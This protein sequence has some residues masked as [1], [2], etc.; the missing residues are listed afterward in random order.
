MVGDFVAAGGDVPRQVGVGFRHLPRNVE[1]AGDALGV[2]QI[3][4][5]GRGYAGPILRHR[6][7][8]GVVGEIGVA[9]QP[10][11]HAVHIKGKQRHALYIIGPDAGHNRSLLLAAG[12]AGRPA[13][14]RDRSSL[15][16]K[17]PGTP[18]GTADTGIPGRIIPPAGGNAKPVRRNGGVSKSGSLSFFRYAGARRRARHTGAGGTAAP[19]LRPGSRKTLAGATPGF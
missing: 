14:S 3:Q 4:D 8:A 16:G 2:Q 17:P 9:P 13:A 1:T 10:R 6:K 15:S 11:G 18:A 5:A 7:Q 19:A 12:G